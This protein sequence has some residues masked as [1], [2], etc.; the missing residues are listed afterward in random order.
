MA[1]VVGR[2]HRHERRASVWRAKPMKEPGSNSHCILAEAVGCGSSRPATQ[3]W[4]HTPCMS[5]APS[6]A[7]KAV[8]PLGESLRRLI[9]TRRV[10]YDSVAWPLR[11]RNRSAAKGQLEEDSMS[12]FQCTRRSSRR[13]RNSSWWSSTSG[14]TGLLHNVL[15]AAL[16]A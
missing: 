11:Q 1:Q 15:T 10:P 4:F 14:L 7:P 12:P 13:G 2:G 3:W 5:M 6:P 16:R 9:P 8:V